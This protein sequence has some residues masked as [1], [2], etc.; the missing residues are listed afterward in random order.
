MGERIVCGG[1]QVWDAVGRAVEDEEEVEEEGEEEDQEYHG[2]PAVGGCFFVGVGPVG[3][4]G[5]AFYFQTQ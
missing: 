2:E 4:C 5:F 1:G 3:A